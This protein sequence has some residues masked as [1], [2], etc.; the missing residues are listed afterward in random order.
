MSRKYRDSPY[1]PPFHSSHIHSSPLST[2]WTTL[3]H[4]LESLN[5]THHWHIIIIQIPWVKFGLTGSVV[6]YMG[7]DLC[8]MTGIYYY[9][10]VKV[11]QSCLTLCNPMDHTVHG[12]F[13]ARILEWVAFPFSRGSSQSRIEPRFPVFLV[14]SLP[15]E[16]QGKTKNTG[17]CSL[18]LLQRIFPTQES[19]RISYI[20]G[21]FFT[22]WAQKER[23]WSRSVVYDSL[24]P[25]GL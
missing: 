8:K 1:H 17:V 6:H 21:G 23:K 24:W 20:A 10:E 16:P 4:F 22:N 13:Q 9:S 11:A 5:L 3:V 25:H 12:I 19:N 7:F 18:S 14:D 2:P 15:A